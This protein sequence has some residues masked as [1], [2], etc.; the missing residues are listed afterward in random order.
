MRAKMEI[1][2][3]NLGDELAL[4]ATGGWDSTLDEFRKRDGTL[5]S[6]SCPPADESIDVPCIWVAE[7]Y[8]PRH[9]ATLIAQLRSL[10]WKRNIG[11][12]SDGLVQ[13][14]EEAVVS[15]FRR[16]WI[17]LGAILRREDENR[18][19]L[20]DLRADLPEIADYAVASM[21]NVLPGAIVFVIQFVL[22]DEAGKRMDRELRTER[23]TFAVYQ[24]TRATFRDPVNQK[25]GACTG[26]RESLRN[27][28]CEWVKRNLPG[29]FS[30]KNSFPTAEAI[31]FQKN[32]PFEH[33]AG[34]F[35]PNNY[36]WVLGMET[37]FDLWA[38]DEL[39]GFKLAIN[40]DR[41]EGKVL[42]LATR[43][44]DFWA[45]ED[46]KELGRKRSDLVG[47][48][49]LGRTLTIWALNAVE[50]DLR[51]SLLIARNNLAEVD[52]KKRGEATKKLAVT[53]AELLQ[54]SGDI[55]P[56]ASQLIDLC[57]HE[58]SFHF[59]VPKFR[60]IGEG[61]DEPALFEGTR[62][63]LMKRAAGL[64]QEERDIRDAAMSMGSL[65]ASES[66]EDA[67][68]TLRT[69][70]VV[71]VLLTIVLVGLAIAQVFLLIA[72]LNNG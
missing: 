65:V 52:L 15:P 22:F 19:S 4:E 53:Q 8:L 28:C 27:E 69:L 14:V 20:N 16:G 39:P 26:V 56:F 17:N 38:S 11:G 57:E 64:R 23:E 48:L 49:S 68:S 66:Q 12:D 5:N 36:L 33:L 29:F 10:G 62:Q 3:T 42:T 72:Q 34:E 18:L 25:R 41:E 46:K 43:V 31:T 71:I 61:P 21:E 24:G 54:L 60:R 63:W 47:R 32:R 59:E 9:F 7:V 40:L 45:G 1:E 30:S 55:V 51:A 6:A 37:A 35:Q 70:T 50:L 2:E 44:D 13:W 58:N 67:N